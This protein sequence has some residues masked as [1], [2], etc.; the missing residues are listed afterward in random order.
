MSQNLISTV[1][2][3]GVCSLIFFVFLSALL[4]KV[5]DIVRFRAVLIAYRLLPESVVAVVAGF[6]ITLEFLSVVG[7]VFVSSTGLALSSMLLFVYMIAMGVNLMRGRVKIDCGCGD[8]PTQLS[9]GL[10]FRNS[11]LILL[12]GSAIAVMP[13][14]VSH[15]LWTMTVAILFGIAGFLIYQA[16]EAILGNSSGIRG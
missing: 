5:R 2:V 4:H 8:S 7:L 13:H 1:F 16:L 6:I 12:A 14:S 9:L 15:T 10:I 3:G 11:L